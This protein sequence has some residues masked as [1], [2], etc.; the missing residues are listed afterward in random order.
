MSIVVSVR[1]GEGLVVAADS[2]ASLQ[3]LGPAGQSLGIAKVF[4]S[5]TKLMQ[6]RDYPIGVAY[7][8]AANI[9]SRSLSSL[10]QE[11]TNPRPELKSACSLSVK[12]EAE[13]LRDFLYDF[14]VR[15]YPGVESRPEG[16]RPS[17]GVFVGGYNPG[18]FFPVEFVFTIPTKEWRQL[19]VPRPDGGQ[20]FGADWFGATDALVRFHHGRDDRLGP[21]LIHNGVAQVTVDEILSAFQR[22]IQYP[23]PFDGMPLQDAI[24]YALFMVGIE[25]GRFRFSAGAELCGGPVDVAAITPHEGFIWIKKKSVQAQVILPERRRN[26]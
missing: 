25:V 21:I 26:R 5:A 23:V 16:Q 4:N 10:V 24:D 15:T 12:E 11:F 19:R 7:W 13:R 8:G 22:E 2:A 6:L 17:V 20:D 1:V 3:A 9:G 14:Y 18:E